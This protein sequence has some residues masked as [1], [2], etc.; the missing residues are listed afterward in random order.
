MKLFPTLF[1][2]PTIWGAILLSGLAGCSRNATPASSEP[3]FREVLASRRSIRSYDD[4][5]SI[6]EAEVRELLTAVQ[7]APSWANTQPTRY[8]VAI[9][10]EKRE[11]LLALL[12]M[13][14]QR[15]QEAPV[16]IVSAYERGFSGFF[17]GQPTDELGDLW[18]A[19]DNGLS[20]A[21][22]VLQARA[23]G[24]DTLIMGLRDAEG[25]RQLFRIPESQT[26]M[27]VIAL[28]YRKS[29]PVRPDRK[30]LDAVVR[31]E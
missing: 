5:K 14:R 26:V 7:D 30:A 15:V 21:Y 17:S 23:M 4:T 19:H 9:S 16:L 25:I 31:F 13:N 24:F 8:Y 11:A 22:L 18:G 20:D 12:G 6:S 28:G 27:S 29:D 10:K 2:H 1:Q 3:T